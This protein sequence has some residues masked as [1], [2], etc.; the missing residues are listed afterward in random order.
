MGGKTLTGKGGAGEDVQRGSY[1]H[2]FIIYTRKVENVIVTIQILSCRRH[3]L[4]AWQIHQWQ[5][6]HIV[7]FAFQLI[8]IMKWKN[9]NEQHLLQSKHTV[10]FSLRHWQLDMP[11]LQFRRWYTVMLSIHCKTLHA[12]LHPPCSLACFCPANSRSRSSLRTHCAE[13]FYSSSPSYHRKPHLCFKTLV[14]SVFKKKGNLND[15]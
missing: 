8:S 3:F 13:M 9:C 15:F 2:N 11:G 12:L 10:F 14:E 1:Q 6:K 4:P 7:T 5:L